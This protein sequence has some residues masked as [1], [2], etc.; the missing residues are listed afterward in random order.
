MG[1]QY[2]N[3]TNSHRGAIVVYNII[4]DEYK[5]LS[6]KQ[7]FES[8]G[9]VPEENSVFKNNI[10]TN[11]NAKKFE[12]EYIVCDYKHFIVYKH[13]PNS[14]SMKRLRMKNRNDIKVMGTWDAMRV[15]LMHRNGMFD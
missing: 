14:H 1:S 10:T 6:D 13:S 11:K 7:N 9:V 15:S 2:D 12:E 3:S 8:I 5:I 4:S